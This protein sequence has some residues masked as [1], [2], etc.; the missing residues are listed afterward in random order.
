[1]SQHLF[2]VGNNF[3]VGNKILNKTLVDSK[4]MEKN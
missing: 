1:M 3:A 4:E 2:S